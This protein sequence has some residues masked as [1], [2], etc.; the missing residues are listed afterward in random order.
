MLDFTGKPQWVKQ[1]VGQ[2]PPATAGPDAGGNGSTAVF[3][4]SAPGSTT[5]GV[6]VAIPYVGVDLAL[7]VNKSYRVQVEEIV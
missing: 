6:K 5:V 3:S 1:G 4:F 2:G 7:D